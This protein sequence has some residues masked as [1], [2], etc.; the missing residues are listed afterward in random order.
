MFGLDYKF[1]LDRLNFFLYNFFFGANFSFIIAV[2]LVFEIWDVFILSGLLNGLF[3]FL[4]WHVWFFLLVPSEFRQGW[5][6]DASL[7]RAQFFDS[8]RHI[9][10]CKGV[11]A[12]FVLVL[13]LKH[14]VFHRFRLLRFGLL[15]LLHVEDEVTLDESPVFRYV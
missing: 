3:A 15:L 14:L 13:R 11:L 8:T 10:L 4:Y 1:S 12:C 9:A 5:H 7:K 2:V 6:L